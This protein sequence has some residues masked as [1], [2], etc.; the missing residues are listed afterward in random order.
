LRDSLYFSYFGNAITFLFSFVCAQVH[1]L[2]NI[3]FNFVLSKGTVLNIFA[4]ASKY[5]VIKRME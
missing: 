4:E 2:V 3:L 5:P 1:L